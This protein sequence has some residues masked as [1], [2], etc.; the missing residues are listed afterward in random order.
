MPAEFENG[1]I[2][3]FAV[4]LTETKFCRQNLEILP[5]SFKREAKTAL[6]H[7]VFKFYRH[8][9]NGVL[10]ITQVHSGHRYDTG[11]KRE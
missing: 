4:L 8:R 9:V 2:T 7:A 1:R 10:D 3:N 6:F 11:N 5:A